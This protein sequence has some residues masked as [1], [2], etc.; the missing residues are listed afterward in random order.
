MRA[1][2]TTVIRTVEEVEPLVRQAL[3]DEGFGVLTEIDVAATPAC[4][5]H[6]RGMQPHDRS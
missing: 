3:A 5:A 1:F 4:T 2:E 6:P